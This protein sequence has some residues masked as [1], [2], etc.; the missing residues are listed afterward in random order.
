VW[1]RRCAL[2]LTGRCFRS[3]VAA[4]SAR[5]PAHCS[6]VTPAKP[7]SGSGWLLRNAE[8]SQKVGLLFACSLWSRARNEMSPGSVA[9]CVSR[10]SISEYQ[11]LCECTS[12][13][14]AHFVIFSGAN[15]SGEQDIYRGTLLMGYRCLAVRMVEGRRPSLRVRPT[16]LGVV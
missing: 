4:V 6:D 8:E 3:R 2:D 7:L 10:D 14:L 9:G 11:S 16:N 5:V 15:G 1:L 12:P 13:A